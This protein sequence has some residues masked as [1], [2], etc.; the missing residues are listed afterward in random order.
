MADGIIGRAIYKLELDSSGIKEGAKKA[1]DEAKNSSS[2]ISGIL[3]GIGKGA[4][5]VAKSAGV[6]MAGAMA[7]ATASVVALGKSA[8]NSYA[9][10]EQL[11]GG[12]ETLFKD[13][14]DQIMEYSKT[15]YKTAGL[16]ANQYMEQATSFSARLIQGLG[17]DTKKASEYANKAIIDMSDNAN[18]MGTD[19]SMIQNAYQG[20]AKQ[21]YTMLDNL[22]LGYGGTASEMARLV[23]DSGVLGKKI[24]V[25]AKTINDV[26][27][28]KIIEAIHK[29]Q[30]GLGIT[31]TTAKEASETISGSV[32]A[33]KGAWEN[34]LTGIASDDV[35]F[36]GLINNFV[37]SLTDVFKNIGPRIQTIAQ[38][39]VKLV[40]A[41]GPVLSQMLP[42]LLQTLLPP[43][44]NAIIQ[45]AIALIPYIPQI[46]QILV[47]AF[48]QNLPIIIKGLLQIIPALLGMIPAL[49]GATLQIFQGVSDALFGQIGEW[50]NGLNDFL[51][52]MFTGMW[53]GLC[54]GA[55]GAWE[56]IKKIFGKV[57]EFF[58]DVFSKAWNAVKKV[59]SVGGKIFDG[60][61]DGI[62]NA[63]KAIVNGIIGGINKVVALPFNAINAVLDRLRDI[64]ILGVHPFGWLG[65]INVPQI[66]KL[67]SGGI[68]PSTNGGQLILAGEAGDDEW[69]V[70]ESKWAS[71]LDQLDERRGGGNITINVSGTFATSEYEQR[72]VAQTI[73]NKIQEIQRQRFNLGAM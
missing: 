48:V 11:V 19:I 9:D 17:G 59:F 71:L 14:A 38:G 64:D 31:G 61:K 42:Q 30:E 26:S 70:P 57:A 13:S 27:F 45:L 34:L 49:I 62:V 69:V 24:K 41:L 15:A 22:K 5:T 1:E 44:L 39:I 51:N 16:S 18:K 21:N 67:A 43:V 12:V 66:P 50:L 68:V 29:T 32:N 52:Q 35:D 7:T 36:S 40:E 33:M 8:L 25:N 46:I 28:D 3:S 73:A 47:D 54:D 58:G 72:K 63:F 4:S 20:F 23:N 37:D 53:N 55:K 2:K 56:G 60:I 10:Y 65:R 6:A